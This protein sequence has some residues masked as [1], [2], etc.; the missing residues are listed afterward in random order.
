MQHSP[1]GE[2][3]KSDTGF[4]RIMLRDGTEIKHPDLDK[5]LEEEREA[6]QKTHDFKPVINIYLKVLKEIEG[7]RAIQY[8]YI[9]AKRQGFDI[10]FESQI[11]NLEN[12]YKNAVIFL[13]NQIEKRIDGKNFNIKKFFKEIIC[14]SASF[15][16]INTGPMDEKTCHLVLF[17]FLECFAK[18]L[19]LLSTYFLK[20]RDLRSAEKYLVISTSIYPLLPDSFNNLAFANISDGKHQNAKK[21]YTKALA[22]AKEAKELCHCASINSNLGEL[23]M[24][25]A[26]LER[27]SNPT[28]FKP[29]SK[30]IT[31]ARKYMI[32]AKQ[33]FYELS[34]SG[35]SA[36]IHAA[37]FI[38]NA[39]TNEANLHRINLEFKQAIA[40]YTEMVADGDSVNIY[41]RYLR[42]I[43]YGLNGDFIHALEDFRVAMVEG[44]PYPL[45]FVQYAWVLKK[46]LE[47]LI[48]PQTSFAEIDIPSKI[49]Y[50]EI[51]NIFSF[52]L[53]KI[54]DNY[55]LNPEDYVI[56]NTVQNLLLDIINLYP[57]FKIKLI[58]KLKNK[59]K[60][61]VNTLTLVR[62]DYIKNF[63][64]DLGIISTE[65][66][67]AEIRDVTTVF[68]TSIANDTESFSNPPPSLLFYQ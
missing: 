54:H 17:Q 28:E 39:L 34:Q 55:L 14:L 38:K 9:A 51:K 50:S 11:D 56:I 68:N 10:D 61:G 41:P 63:L 59:L 48:N 57:P 47:S 18:I 31:Q 1:P 13:I 44:F 24:L 46:Y 35:T 16:I 58:D 43:A 25:L 19:G 3:Q 60:L 49:P 62:V 52:I 67:L 26:D 42:A 30:T 37:Y 22:I 15:G 7:S 4:I 66:K 2:D 5:A 27:V 12:Q 21:N 64:I 45:A 8:I 6:E 29:D 23:F 20:Q 33:D 32:Q 53:E 36:E 40:C 65:E